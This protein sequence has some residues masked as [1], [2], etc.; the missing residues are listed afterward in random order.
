M[1]DAGST[2]IMGGLHDGG[3]PYDVRVR[4]CGG[5]VNGTVDM[6]FCGEVDDGVVSA[7]CLVQGRFI[8]N[9]TVDKGEAG[10]T[11]A[12]GEVRQRARVGEGVIDGDG[13]ELR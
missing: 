3:S 8:A 10:V 7:H 4:K 5:S 1:N 11:S 13:F 2:D 6:R 12:L 9:V